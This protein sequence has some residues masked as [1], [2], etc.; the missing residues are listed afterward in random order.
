MVRAQVS[1]NPKAE[2]VEELQSRRK[3]LH[4]G[5]CKLLRE[6]LSIQAG[7]ELAGCSAPPDTKRAIK[8]RIIND[9]DCQILQH[10]QV[11]AD[12]FNT[13]AEYK[14]L[15]NEAID[16]KAYAL[17]KLRIYHQSLAAEMGQSHQQTIFSAPLAGFANKATV[18]RLRT[19]IADFPWEAVVLERSADLDLGEWDA[20]SAS[21]QARE[22]VLGALG[23]NSNVRSV[24]I[25]G[26]KLELSQGWATKELKWAG[27][28]AA[29]SVPATVALLLR[30][31]GSLQ[32]LYLRY[33]GIYRFLPHPSLHPSPPPLPVPVPVPLSCPNAHT[34]TPEFKFY[35][36]FFISL[37]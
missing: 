2:T 33:P 30:N 34:T 19:G 23:E 35:F 32:I 36:L 16:S 27:K 3:N 13:D 22:L 24:R 10:K 4:M 15:M 17:E 21:A 28:V 1:V 37:F 11:E 26:V 20:A 5:M 25:K 6:D 31:C 9:F 8:Q 18:L 29:F 14:R 7:V 12:A